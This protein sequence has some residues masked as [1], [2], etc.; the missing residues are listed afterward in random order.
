M[1]I[2]VRKRNLNISDDQNDCDT[3]L[4]LKTVKIHK[5]Q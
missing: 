1:Y 5:I 3:I 4:N 2:N